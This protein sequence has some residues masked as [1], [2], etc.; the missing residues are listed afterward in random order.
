[1]KI[2]N[3]IFTESHDLVSWFTVLIAFYLCYKTLK[4][5]AAVTV[6]HIYF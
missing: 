1:M 5:K 6:V 2:A 3:E 4:I